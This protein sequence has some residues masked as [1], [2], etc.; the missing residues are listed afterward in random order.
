MKI[1]YLFIPSLYYVTCERSTELTTC[2][3]E[4]FDMESMVLRQ[5]LGP[6]VIVDSC[7]VHN[8]AR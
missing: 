2:V 7:H 6:S 4:G 8:N 3:S 5:S 1:S